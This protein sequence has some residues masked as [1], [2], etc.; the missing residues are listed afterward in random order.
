MAKEGHQPPYGWP[1]R[2]QSAPASLGRAPLSR[3]PPVR[4]LMPFFGCK[5][6]NF[7]KTIWAK[8]SV[9][10]E[11]RISIY[12]RNGERADR[13]TQKQRETERQI[14][15]RRGSRPSQS[16]SQAMGAKDQRENPSPIWGGGQVRKIRRG[17]LSPCDARIV[18]LQ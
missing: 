5:K 2:A 10:S 13:R 3:G 11:L 14:Q 4:R 8:V 15:S 7:W 17:P 1:T 9:Q 6:A 12:I 18:K 16:P